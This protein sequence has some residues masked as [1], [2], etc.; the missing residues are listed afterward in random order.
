MEEGNKVTMPRQQ[1][2]VTKLLILTIL[3]V[4]RIQHILGKG[5]A[6][7]SSVSDDSTSN[8]SWNIEEHDEVSKPAE[9]GSREMMTLHPTVLIPILAR[10][11]EHTLA[12]FFGCLERLQYPK[13]RISLW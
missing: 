1:N 3:L 8:R 5:T 2:S 13:D 9:P 7:G 11:K 4:L 6:Q 10:N 12:T